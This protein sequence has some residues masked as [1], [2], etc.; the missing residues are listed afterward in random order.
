MAAGRPLAVRLRGGVDVC[1]SD[2]LGGLVGVG[3]ERQGGRQR[4]N[5]TAALLLAAVRLLAVRLRGGVDVYGSGALGGRSAV[6]VGGGR[7]RW[8]LGGGGDRRRWASVLIWAA[9]RGC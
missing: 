7:R 1:D 6:G 5:G 2:A 4:G 9:A 8:A 3:G